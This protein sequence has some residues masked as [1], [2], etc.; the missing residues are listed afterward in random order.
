[1]VDGMKT[2][3]RRKNLVTRGGIGWGVFEIAA[4]Q[5]FVCF[6]GHGGSIFSIMVWGSALAGLTRCCR[7]LSPTD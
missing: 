1:M 3:D 7:R 5:G 4:N 2:D 6:D